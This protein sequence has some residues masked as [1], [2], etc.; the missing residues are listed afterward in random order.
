MQEHSKRRKTLKKP[1]SD[2]TTLSKEQQ[3]E[4][5]QALYVSL[6]HKVDRLSRRY[7]INDQV[8]TDYLLASALLTAASRYDLPLETMPEV[9][10]GIVAMLQGWAP[11]TDTV[12]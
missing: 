7:G 4:L 3:D 1:P 9:A 6:N 2:V 5:G 11:S 10:E 12:Q 8:A